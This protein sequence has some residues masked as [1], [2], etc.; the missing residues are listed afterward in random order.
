MAKTRGKNDLKPCPFCGSNVITKK[1]REG[2]TFFECDTCKGVTFF[3]G[4]VSNPS[5]AWNRRV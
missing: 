4:K 5:E 1:G 2:T 3:A